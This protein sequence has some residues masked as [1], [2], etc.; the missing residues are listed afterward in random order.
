MSI[1]ERTRR[2]FDSES[3]RE[4]R[5]QALNNL[6]DQVMPD[7]KR[8]VNFNA[9]NR[10]GPAARRLRQLLKDSKAPVAVVDGKRPKMLRLVWDKD[11]PEQRF[12]LTVVVNAC[13]FLGADYRE[14]LE[15]YSDL[16]DDFSAL[17]NSM[18]LDQV[19]SKFSSGQHCSGPS[20]GALKVN[21]IN[22]DRAVVKLYG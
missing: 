21:G 17:L 11:L 15:N 5:K 10:T 18:K 2:L 1:A 3:R 19:F 4:E 14:R 9:A 13:K 20:K 8:L 22:P 7:F 6:A 12:Y 16:L